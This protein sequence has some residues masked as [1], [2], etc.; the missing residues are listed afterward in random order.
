MD[1]GYSAPSFTYTPYIAKLSEITVAIVNYLTLQTTFQYYA[2]L[3]VRERIT[4]RHTTK[5]DFYTPSLRGTLEIRSLSAFFF[6]CH[7]PVL[8]FQSTA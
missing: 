6:V 8:Y 7:C 4:I 5:I 3:S 1:L 2:P